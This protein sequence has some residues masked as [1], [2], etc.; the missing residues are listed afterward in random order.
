MTMR[1]AKLPRRAAD[2]QIEPMTDRKKQS[3][4]QLMVKGMGTLTSM[5][6]WPF[7]FQNYKNMTGNYILQSHLGLYEPKQL[8][9]WNLKQKTLT[10]PLNAD[11]PDGHAYK[12]WG[13]RKDRG[14]PRR[15]HLTLTYK[16]Y[17]SRIL[18]G[19]IR[20][21]FFVCQDFMLGKI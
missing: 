13:R 6:W 17:R 18:S 20:N 4:D 5:K 14:T 16:N 12:K 3:F 10:F 7:R 2:C 8:K 21:D 19:K 9:D 11:D 15:T 1:T